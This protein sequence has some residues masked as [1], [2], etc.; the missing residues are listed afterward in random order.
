MLCCKF[1]DRL[2]SFVCATPGKIPNETVNFVPPIALKC[3]NLHFTQN[4]CRG[5][6]RKIEMVS[7]IML[8]NFKSTKIAQGSSNFA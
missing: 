3:S 4:N 1:S 8:K 5:S 6:I 7:I 2:K